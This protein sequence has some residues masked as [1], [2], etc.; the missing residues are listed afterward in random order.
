LISI[1]TLTEPLG[2]LVGSLLT[3]FFEREATLV[4][5]GIAGAVASGTFVY[6]AVVDIMMEE[7]AIGRDKYV[8]AMFC[9]IGYGLMTSLV[10]AIP[11]DEGHTHSHD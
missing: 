10:Y 4:I 8:K 7:F 2:I 3:V 1:Y 9:L 11:H 6:V 5:E